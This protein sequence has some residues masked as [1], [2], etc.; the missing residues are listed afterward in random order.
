MPPRVSVLLPVYNQEKY[1]REAIDS[2]LAQTYSDFEFIIIDD[3]SS[4][5]SVKVIQQFT[6]ERIRFY[7]NTKNLG[8]VRTL[9]EGLSL[10]RGEYI[11]RMDGDDIAYPERFQKQVEFLDAHPDVGVV[12]AAVQCFSKDGTGE[13]MRYETDCSALF[14]SFIFAETSMVAHPVVMMRRN[15]F[16]S[17]IKYSQR[18]FYAEDYKL[19]NDLK[20]HTNITNLPEVLLKYRIHPFSMSRTK[21]EKQAL[22]RTEIAAAEYE[23]LLGER[24][25]SKKSSARAIF[26]SLDWFQLCT[27]TRGLQQHTGLGDALKI[28][29]K[30]LFE[31]KIVPY[32]VIM[33]RFIIRGISL[34]VE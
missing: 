34:Y 13:V 9:N 17:G 23:R 1:I 8:S 27:L 20:W 11:A 32:L 18:Y 5:M 26:R 24:I 22:L 6:D 3:A 31:S 15:L 33:K 30:S 21:P 29:G 19:W 16:A 4:D 2:I 14:S 12:G 7:V 25:E 28:I 10:C